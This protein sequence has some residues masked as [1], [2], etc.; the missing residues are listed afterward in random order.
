VTLAERYQEQGK[1][2]DSIAVYED[3]VHNAG[4][5]DWKQAAKERARI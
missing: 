3:I 4:N 2:K 5:P 1:V